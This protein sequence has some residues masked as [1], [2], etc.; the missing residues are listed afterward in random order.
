M[1]I[2]SHYI[3][4]SESEKANPSSVVLQQI[5]VGKKTCI[6]VCICDGKKEGEQG[7]R[8]AGYVTESLVE[9]FHHRCIPKLCRESGF[10]VFGRETENLW[11]KIQGELEKEIRGAMTR[12]AQNRKL[13]LHLCGML[14]WEEQFCYF[15]KGDTK[16]YLFNRRFNKK[17]CRDL[18]L[19]LFGKE[20]GEDLQM[21]SGELQKG[22]S[23][24]FSTARYCEHIS[25]EEMLEVL[26][27]EKDTELRIRK[28]LKE[29][30][31]EDMLRGGERYVGA[32]F[33]RTE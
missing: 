29:L 10:S 27:V 3:W 16:G 20:R 18:Q 2:F 31:K 12:A 6:L 4:E 24:L 19:L 28:K 33:I 23:I 25:K 5:K 30:W 1:N 14:I 7:I 22:V 17:Q 26:F 9:W 13:T 11:S 15:V 21:I 32:V 8:G